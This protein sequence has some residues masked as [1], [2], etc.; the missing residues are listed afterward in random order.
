MLVS[1]TTMLIVMRLTAA[2]QKLLIIWL[3]MEQM[4]APACASKFIWQCSSNLCVDEQK[5]TLKENDEK[6]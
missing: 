3:S 1:L 4:L 2:I 5:M 6:T